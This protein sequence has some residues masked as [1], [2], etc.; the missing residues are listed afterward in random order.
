MKDALAEKLLARIMD[1]KPEDVALQMRDLQV[2]STMKY[3]NYQ[4][5]APGMRF[6]ESLALWLQ[7]FNTK[8]ERDCTYDFVRRRLIFI[9]E[10][11]MQHLVTIAFPDFIRPFLLQQAS[12]SSGNSPFKL[13]K[14]VNGEHYKMALRKS[15]FLALS[16]GAHIDMFRRVNPLLTHEQVLPYYRID[17]GEANDLILKLRNDLERTFS[18]K[19]NDPRFTNL[20][21]LDDFSGSG[22]SYSR[23][24]GD[25]FDGK[26]IRVMKSIYFADSPLNTLFNKS[27]LS[28]IVVLYS[29]TERAKK[30]IKE[31]VGEFQRK[32]NCACNFHLITIQ[33]L[34]AT[35]RVDNYGDSKLESIL[36]NYFDDKIVDADYKKGKIDNPHYGFDECAL[37]LILYHNAPNNTIPILWFGGDF[38]Y[39]GLFPRVS[40][41]KE[42]GSLR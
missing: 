15:L 17:E 33:E 13:N 11:E 8:E 28:I 40:R 38:N 26:I 34:P 1:W 9:S 41:H 10:L 25:N 27:D 18:T 6:V 4:Q 21:L 29:A 2:L 16:D 23:R 12:E 24:D 37:P 19:D 31:I 42:G 20:F 7:Q 14:L 3:N 36:K 39:H 5:F 35:L 32:F 22:Y 30:R